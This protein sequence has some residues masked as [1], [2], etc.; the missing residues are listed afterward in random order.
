[1]NIIPPE[2]LP[3]LP[4]VGWAILLGSIP[5]VAV[6]KFKYFLNAF[7][8]QADLNNTIKRGWVLT[9]YIL[10]AVSLISIALITGGYK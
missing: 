1:M 5:I 10:L 2:I 3:Y 9:D 6:R 8:S 4:L 7:K